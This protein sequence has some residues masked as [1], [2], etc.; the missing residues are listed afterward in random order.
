MEKDERREV[1]TQRKSPVVLV[2]WGLRPHLEA[3]LGGLVY[4]NTPEFYRLHAT[5]AYGDRNESCGYSYRRVRDTL[6]PTFLIDGVEVTGIVALTAARGRGR[7]FYLQCWT[8]VTIPDDSAEL[9]A[10]K[11]D[12]RRMTKEFGGDYVALRADGVQQY[13]ERLAAADGRQPASGLVT[14]TD[15]AG[16]W[17]PTCKGIEFRHQREFRLLVGPCKSLDTT[18]KKLFLPDLHDLLSINAD[19]E[20]SYDGKRIFRMHGGAITGR[21][22]QVLLSSTGS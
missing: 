19:L 14:Y 3:L 11:R 7:E 9:R 5:K 16:Q 20:M 22:G 4:L 2:K 17:G 18:P 6:P 8:A 1:V 13:L 10:M 21:E 15:V 12:F